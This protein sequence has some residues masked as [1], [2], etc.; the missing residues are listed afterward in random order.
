MQLKKSVKRVIHFMMMLVN[1]IAVLF[2]LCLN[3][4]VPIGLFLTMTFLINTFYHSV[5]YE[6]LEDSFINED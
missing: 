2:A 6:M 3:T 4:S 1:G 5:K